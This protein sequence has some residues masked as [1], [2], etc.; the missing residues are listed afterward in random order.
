[1]WADLN[2]PWDHDHIIPQNWIGENAEWSQFCS[3]WINSIGNI[4][5]IPFELNRQKQDKADLLYYCEYADD[6]LFEPTQEI[7]SLNA[8]LSEP[9]YDEQRRVF[10][11]FVRKRFLA[12]AEPFL[13]ILGNLHLS[14]DLS[15]N[16][17]FRKRII[18]SAW[19]KHPECKLYYLHNGIEYEFKEEE[20][21]GWQQVWV[22]LSKDIGHP[23]R[24]VSLTLAIDDDN[25]F[26]A[27]C[28]LRKRPLLHVEQMSNHNWWES[29]VRGK[30]SAEE[31]NGEWRAYSYHR[32]D[33]LKEFDSLMEKYH[34]NSF[35]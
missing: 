26:E 6:L 5:D 20:I 14:D 25:K 27:E 2:R 3:L 19:K 34:N 28:G 30:V 4:A 35:E 12:I 10:F 11:N 13:S 9:G 18:M 15:K 32:W 31:V 23:E 8:K 33:L 24:V 7:L 17:L 22:S 16:Q 29:I 21:Y 1:M